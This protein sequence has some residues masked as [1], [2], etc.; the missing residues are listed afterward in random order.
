MR[1]EKDIGKIIRN[2]RGNMS[3]RDFAKKCDISHTTI[4]NLEKGFDFRTGKPVQA[5]IAT[6]KKIA[7]SCGVPLSYIVGEEDQSSDTN[8]LKVPLFGD[9]P[10]KKKIILDKIIEYAKFLNAQYEQENS[11]SFN[12][13]MEAAA[14]LRFSMMK[15]GMRTL[16]LSEITKIPATE[17]ACYLDG[18]VLPTNEHYT[19]LAEE[20]RVSKEWLMCRDNSISIKDALYPNADKTLDYEEWLNALEF[21]ASLDQDYS[22]SYRAARSTNYSANDL[23]STNEEDEDD[24]FH[25]I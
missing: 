23:E 20:L 7:D 4:D 5:K 8:E 12:E 2:L 15:A 14:R 18:L 11:A 1:N 19:L 6:L 9:D 10:E 3:L 13:K 16:K 25:S 24:T 22:N 21:T 17:I